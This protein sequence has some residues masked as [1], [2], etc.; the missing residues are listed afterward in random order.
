ML[1]V[2]SVA[3]LAHYL[4][5]YPS[6]VLVVSHDRDF[7]DE[8]ATDIIHQH[9]E[10]LDYYKGDFTTFQSTKDERAKNQLREYENQLALRKHLQTFID[11]FRY[12]AAKSSEAQSRIKKL[13]RLPKLEP[14]EEERS[15][16][17]VF[18]EPEKLPLPILR[19]NGVGFGYN[20]EKLLLKGI[21]IDV[22]MESRIGIVGANGSGKTTMLKVLT[23]QL[24]PIKGMV[25]RHPRLRIGF[26]AQHHVDALDLTA[27]AVSFMARTYP[28]K[29]DEE[30]RRALG[31]FGITGATGLQLMETLSGGQKS[32]VAFACLALQNPHILILDEPTNHLDLRAM[33][34]LVGALREFKG[35]TIHSCFGGG[36]MRQGYCSLVMTR[37]F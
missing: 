22:D 26:F 23:E 32:R 31:N 25:H 8:V 28:G 20:P 30:Y 17:F 14:P 13:E 34:A 16:T 24:E 11:K 19:M 29:S 4:L 36:L 27:S 15:L 12:N 6:T 37:R 1:D 3:Y 9:N 7:L 33:D 18:P 10:R 21:D 2:P 35:G 5:S